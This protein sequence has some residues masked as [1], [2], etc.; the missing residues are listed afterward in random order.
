[1]YCQV[2]KVRFPEAE[3]EDIVGIATESG[4]VE[5]PSEDA[6]YLDARDWSDE[7]EAEARRIQAEFG[8]LTRTRQW[9]TVVKE[10]P[11]AEA[12]PPPFN[13]PQ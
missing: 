12:A 13:S 3:A 9:Q 6:L 10:Y 7:N 4:F 11:G 1:M 2:V 5:T 8:L